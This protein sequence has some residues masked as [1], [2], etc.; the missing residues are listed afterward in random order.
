MAT[1]IES[2]V[3]TVNYGRQTAKGTI[4]TAATTSVG[5]NCPKHEE[6]AL[7]P[8]KKLGQQE[9]TD[10]NRFASPSVWTDQIGGEVGGLTVQL[11]PE[12]AGLYPAAVLGVD[13]VTG[14]SDPYTHTITSAGTAGQWGTWWQKVGAAVGPERQVYYD[15]KIAKLV[16]K[17]SFQKKGLLGMI[18]VQALIAGQKYTTDA[19]KT[20]DASDPYLHTEAVGTYTI[21]GLAVSEVF[22][23]TLDIDTLM[24]PFYGDGTLPVQLIEGKG[25]I[26]RSMKAI[27][28]DALLAKTNL[29]IWNSATPSGGTNPSPVVWAPALSCVY[30]RSATR[31]LT[32]TTPKVAVDPDNITIAPLPQG[33]EIEVEFTGACLKSGASP[34]VTIVAL[35][36]DATTYA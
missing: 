18:D 33:G 6:G 30:T 27:V 4:A 13:V 32:I 9:Y 29:A 1:V 16:M 22:E 31:T 8:G 21:D 24:K 17:S 14:A 36:G 10:G 34:A 15:S 19:A 7:K 28:T 5:Y 35:S 2:G 26:T 23:H 20:E 11:Q 12:N 25:L 3:G